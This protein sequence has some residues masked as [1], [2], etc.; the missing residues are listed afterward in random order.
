M[1][2]NFILSE[3]VYDKELQTADADVE[4]MY[5]HTADNQEG[6][7]QNGRTAR[8]A[9]ECMNVAYGLLEAIPP[10]ATSEMTLWNTIR[11]IHEMCRTEGI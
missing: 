3:V 11:S 9:L 2:R 6:S 5:L 1:N 4:A 8:D 10:E 7:M